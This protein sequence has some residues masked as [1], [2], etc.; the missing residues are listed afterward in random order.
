VTDWRHLTPRRSTRSAPLPP[1]PILPKSGYADPELPCLKPCTSV[2]QHVPD[3]VHLTS[4]VPLFI[5]D[6]LGNLMQVA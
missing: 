5:V 3:A 2:S 4:T 1:D 6:H